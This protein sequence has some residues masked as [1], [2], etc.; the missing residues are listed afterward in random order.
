MYDLGGPTYPGIY[1]SNHQG[2]NSY[3]PLKSDFTKPC[4]LDLTEQE[5]E[6]QCI[7]RQEA[8]WG[9][10]RL[11]RLEAI[12]KAVDPNHMLNCNACIGKNAFPQDSSGEREAPPSLGC[13][14]GTIS[15]LQILLHLM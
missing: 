4:P 12:K 8:I 6:A 13:L 9:T 5:R 2:P 3:G 11:A 14:L 10:E 15:A 7:S 1:G